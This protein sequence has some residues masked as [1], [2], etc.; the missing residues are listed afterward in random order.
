MKT[1]QLVLGVSALAMT[2]F[3]TS[4][5]K[6]NINPNGSANASTIATKASVTALLLDDTT[7]PKWKSGNA[8]AEAT[9]AASALGVATPS[10][11]L[12][13]DWD[14]E[15]GMNDTH[16]NP[17]AVAGTPGANGITI[18]N[19]TS[20]TFTW[21]S[22]RKVYI[23]IVKGGNGANIYHYPQGS[24]G[25]SALYAPENASGSSAAI[26]HVTFCWN[27]QLCEEEG[28]TCYAKESAWTAGPRYVNK[29]NWA[30]Y[31]AYPGNGGTVNIF[32]GQT[33]NAGTATFVDNLNGTVTITVNLTG[34]FSFYYDLTNPTGNDNV[35]IHTYSNAPSGTPAPG[36]FANKGSA[37]IGATTY[38]MTV[39]MANF[40]G[41][42]LDLARVVPCP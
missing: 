17:N 21:S 1:I 11:A 8:M 35:K 23:V 7:N 14:A 28:E 13:I 2:F 34:T 27:N 10:F 36:L 26:S 16:S 6:E 18:T 15:A 40:Y 12:K 30:T 38:S 25:D 41:I 37:S 29:G 5:L 24:C 22:P 31:T 4:C 39:P 42:H 9:L 20:H 19:S 33:M 3:F 32:A